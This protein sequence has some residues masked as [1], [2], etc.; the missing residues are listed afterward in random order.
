MKAE[1]HSENMKELS[2]ASKGVTNA[3]GK[4]V[5]SAKSGAQLIE[6]LGEYQGPSLLSCVMH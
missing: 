1:R 2:E 6:D 5:A 4:V 3:T